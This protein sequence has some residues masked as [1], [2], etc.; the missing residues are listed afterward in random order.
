MISLAS[1]LH[2]PKDAG[3]GIKA[4]GCV[5]AKGASC[6]LASTHLGYHPEVLYVGPLPGHLS[7]STPKKSEI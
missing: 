3:S 5:V 4:V 6:D 1:T 7:L 2:V